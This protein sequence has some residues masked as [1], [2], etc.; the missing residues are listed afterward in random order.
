MTTAT[1]KSPGILYH[2]ADLM[3][4][5]GRKPARKPDTACDCNHG[6]NRSHRSMNVDDGDRNYE[7]TYCREC[8]CQWKSL[9]SI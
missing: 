9:T 4:G 2:M 7:I 3:P 5:A 1:R 6:L 8:N